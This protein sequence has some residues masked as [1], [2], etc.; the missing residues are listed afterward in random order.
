PESGSNNLP[1]QSGSDDA[2]FVPSAGMGEVGTGGLGVASASSIPSQ[3]L[4]DDKL[5]LSAPRVSIEQKSV[6]ALGGI[7]LLAKLGQGGMGA[8]YFGI[9]PRL[10]LDVAVKVLPFNL[11]E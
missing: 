1:G 9:H 6:P 10:H 4:S 3:D 11:A 7:P 2:T 8:V 5:L